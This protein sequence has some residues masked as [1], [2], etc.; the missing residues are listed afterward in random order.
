[1]IDYFLAVQYCNPNTLSFYHLNIIDVQWLSFGWNFDVCLLGSSVKFIKQ[2]F[3]N[4]PT[5]N[6][7]IDFYVERFCIYTILLQ[8]QSN[9]EWQ[10]TFFH[11]M[12]AS[13]TISVRVAY[14]N[15]S[16]DVLKMNCNLHKSILQYLANCKYSLIRKAISNIKLQK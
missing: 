7:L 10:K 9:I 3:F 16:K 1:M 11:D 4:E 15:S 13:Y 8:C 6:Q 2:P 12:H 5:F 14:S